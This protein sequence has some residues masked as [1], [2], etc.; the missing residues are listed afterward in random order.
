MHIDSNQSII[1]KINNT[2]ETIHYTPQLAIGIVDN[3]SLGYYNV[4]KSIIFFDKRGNDR[5]PPPHIEYP[6]FTPATTTR[7]LK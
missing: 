5:I 4:S 6:S 3:R 2:E 1:K 7:P